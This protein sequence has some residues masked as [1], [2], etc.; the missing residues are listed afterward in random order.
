MLQKTNSYRSVMAAAALCGVLVMS[1]HAGYSDRRQVIVFAA[2]GSSAGERMRAS[3]DELRCQLQD[4]D[5]DVRFVDTSDLPDADAVKTPA[6]VIAELM[7]LRSK[8]NPDFEMLLIGKD[9]GVKARTGDPDALEDFLSQIDTMP[10]R[11]AEMRAE[12]G[13]DSACQPEG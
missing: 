12:G 6:G 11:R 3:V 5:T 9:G 8:D 4:R 1:S 7:Q 13:G 2:P 10:M